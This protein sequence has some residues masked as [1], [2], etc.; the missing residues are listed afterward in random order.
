[1]MGG[2]FFT[3]EFGRVLVPSLDISRTPEPG[4]FCDIKKGTIIVPFYIESSTLPMVYIFF[5]PVGLTEPIN[6]ETFLTGTQ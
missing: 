2:D 5:A 4:L 3:S 6:V 1:M